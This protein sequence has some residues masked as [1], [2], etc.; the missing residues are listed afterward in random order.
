MKS[1]YAS[2]FASVS[3]IRLKLIITRWALES[4]QIDLCAAKW[5][6]RLCFYDKCICLDL[7]ESCHAKT[8]KLKLYSKPAGGKTDGTLFLWS[9][10]N[11]FYTWKSDPVNISRYQMS[12]QIN[13]PKFSQGL[14]LSYIYKNTEKYNWQS[15]ECK[16]Q[17][18]G[19]TPGSRY[20]SF[21][22]LRIC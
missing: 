22:I 8:V 7:I 11:S 12:L 19:T 2:E 20:P 14:R 9:A 16:Y 21:G 1:S 10:S 4:L 3:N 13:V 17:T 5:N 15:P 6:V 18:S